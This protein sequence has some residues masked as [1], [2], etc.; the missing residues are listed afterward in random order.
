VVNGELMEFYSMSVGNGRW[1]MK[2]T[3]I[4]KNG[5]YLPPC[6]IEFYIVN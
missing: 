6:E 3:V 1:K 4:D 2:M 5:N